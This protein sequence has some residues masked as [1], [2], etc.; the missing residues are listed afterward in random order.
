LFE[1]EKTERV[2]GIRLYL[3]DTRLTLSTRR[4]ILASGNHPAHFAG[5]PQQVLG[6]S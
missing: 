5:C 4:V 1:R 2:L 6:Y 3:A